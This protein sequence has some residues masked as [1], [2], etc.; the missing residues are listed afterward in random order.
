MKSCFTLKTRILISIF[1]TTLNTQVLATNEEEV[2]VHGPQ[3]N[4]SIRPGGGGLGTPGT[5]GA[6]GRING[7]GGG[8]SGSQ[9]SN[10]NSGN[11]NENQPN[12]P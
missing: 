10:N 4:D 3:G 8:N 7:S 9:S 6:G 2:I 12:E 11:N 1:I 5:P